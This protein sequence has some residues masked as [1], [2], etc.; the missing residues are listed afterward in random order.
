MKKFFL[1]EEY[2]DLEFLPKGLGAEEYFEDMKVVQKYAELN[3]EAMLQTIIKDFFHQE[4]KDLEKIHTIHNYISFEDNILRKGAISA[5][6]GERVLIPISMKDGI[7]V[8]KGKG[9]K[10][11]NYSAP[12]GAGRLMGRN[13]AKKNLSLDV[14]KAEM[15]GV[16]SSCVD[17]DRLDEAP[18]AYKPM[19]DILEAIQETVEVEFV[20][21]EIYNFKAKG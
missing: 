10:K 8:A 21:P 20:M 17:A 11:W 9:S 15:K 3:R 13:D 7:I 4:P 12:H 5:H 14:F 18:M 16:W 6:L 19:A 2:K 1:E